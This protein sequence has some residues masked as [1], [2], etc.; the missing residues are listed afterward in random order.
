MN[1]VFVLTGLIVAS[2]F[3]TAANTRQ[4][5]GSIRNA[6]LENKAFPKAM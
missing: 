4:L 5:S 6:I 3:F 1:Y 2:F